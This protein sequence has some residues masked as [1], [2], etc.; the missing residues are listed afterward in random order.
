M[1]K[2]ALEETRVII[3]RDIDIVLACQKA[4]ALAAQLGLS[5]D[6]QVAVV[7]ATSEVARNIFKYAGQ[8][9]I[10][11]SPLYRDGQNGILIVAYDEG[12]GIPDI[13]QAMQDGYS[14][15]G[16]LGLGL[17]G[18]KRLMDAFGIASELGKGTTVTMKKWSC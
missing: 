2:V 3:R 5:G 7:I 13:E 4:R 9:S 12:P 17:C 6:D 8:G 15:G 16:G 10:V 14:T 11:I 1:V 18:A